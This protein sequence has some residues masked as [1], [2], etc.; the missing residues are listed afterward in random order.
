MR[1]S[2]FYLLPLMFCA[3]P[4]WTIQHPDR[5]TTLENCLVEHLLTEFVL[6]EPD[7]QQF[8]LSLNHGV[9]INEGGIVTQDG[10]ILK[11]T[12]T[13]CEDQHRL[14][15]GNRNIAE[16]DPLFFDGRLAVISSPGQENWY[17]WLF[18]VLPR[19]K[20]LADSKVD[21][22]RIYLNNL[23]FKWQ[24]ESLQIVMNQL[25]ISD[26]QLFLREG[27]SIIEATTLIVPSVPFI[28]SKSPAFPSWL[29]DFIHTAFLRN[30]ESANM[31]ERIYISR[32]KANLR[33]I[34]NEDALT[35]VLKQKGFVVVFL[36][37]MPIYQ[38][39]QFFHHA[40]IIIGPHGSGFANLI[41][42]KPNA[43]LIEI[44]HG[45]VG[46]QRSFYKRLSELVDCQYFGF[47]PDIVQEDHLEM[48]IQMNIED[49]SLF[50]NQMNIF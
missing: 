32:S 41:F 3:L 12:E 39:A 43:W 50:C 45:L 33:R 22:D 21:Y 47:Y 37:E 25:N 30:T 6:T 23:K 36:E 7:S 26:Q 40:K 35:E 9:V 4:C 5:L 13:F 1:R 49:F 28:P 16:E 34:I 11:D 48:D 15:K 17:H 27:D 18:Q 14:L 19:L 20:V 10:K 2:L 38:Q 24:R 44:D 31:P 42:C 46:E 29:K 8:V